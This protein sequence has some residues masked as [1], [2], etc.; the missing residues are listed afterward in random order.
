MNDS[1]MQNGWPGCRT[2]V[3]EL[4][5]IWLGHWYRANL[6]GGFLGA[7]RVK[8]DVRLVSFALSGVRKMDL[9]LRP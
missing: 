2:K 1:A 4:P 7:L 8:M 9:G 6:P 5:V 3:R